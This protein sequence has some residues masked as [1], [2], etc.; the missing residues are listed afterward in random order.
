MLL[1]NIFSLGLY[2]LYFLSLIA[3]MYTLRSL[4][5]HFSLFIISTYTLMTLY[6]INSDVYKE[7]LFEVHLYLDILERVVYIDSEV[8]YVLS[9]AHLL[10]LV[11]LKK[12]D[13]FWDIID[14]KLLGNLKNVYKRFKVFVMG[15]FY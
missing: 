11:N 12:F 10:L 15:R 7:L 6:L 9:T 3:S 14:K 13:I 1:L 4:F 2:T 8:M 5:N